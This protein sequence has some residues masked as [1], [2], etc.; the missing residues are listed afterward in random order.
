MV[1]KGSVRISK[2]SATGEEALAVLEPPAFFG[3]MAL[4][5]GSLA[6][7]DLPEADRMRWR[8]QFEHYV[9]SGGEAAARHL[10]EQA[11][12][13]LGPLGADTAGQIKAKLLRGLSR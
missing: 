8:D 12:G 1:V 9:F 7:R 11:R 4:L 5:D 2:Q 13:I 6:I 3:E 10:P